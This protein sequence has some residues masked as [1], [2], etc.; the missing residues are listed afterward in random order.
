MVVYAVAYLSTAFVFFGLDFLWLGKVATG[1]YRS[2]LGEMM[3]DRPDFA[4]AGAFYLVYVAGIVYFAVQPNLQGGSWTQALLSGAI[5]G[6][7]A[8]GTY[9]MTN[10]ATLKNWPITVTLVDLAWGTA[11]TGTSAAIG[12]LVTRKLLG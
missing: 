4:A 2:Q 1:F 8:Y 7:I 5:L 10:L 12:L 3:R 9:D 6:L 11:L